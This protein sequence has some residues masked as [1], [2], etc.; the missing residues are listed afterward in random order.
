MKQQSGR[1]KNNKRKRGNAM[2][3]LIFT[4]GFIAV[5]V[6]SMILAVTPILAATE[7]GVTVTATPAYIA[8]TNDPDV[9]TLNDLVG[10]GVTPKGTIGPDTY[11][12]SNPLGDELVP[13]DDV[14]DGECTFTIT[15]TSTITT[16]VFVVISDFAGGSCD[17]TNSD[18]GSNGATTFGAYSYC[19]GMTYSTGKVICKVS[20]SLATKEDLA[21]TTDIKWGIGIESQTDAWAGGSSSTATATV[22]LAAV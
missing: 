12:Y 6:S 7:E 11:Y 20:G 8:M 18:D 15:N 5:L 19:T 16:D 10:D 14:V 9:W 4:I 21:P 17:M 22:S 1:M 13:S 2:K 3:R